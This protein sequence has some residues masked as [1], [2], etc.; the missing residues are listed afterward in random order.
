MILTNETR[1]PPAPPRTPAAG[2]R[3]AAVPPL[4]PGAL[5]G[6]GHAPALLRDPLGFLGSLSRYGDVVRIRLGPRTVCVV[7]D[8]GL[9]H[10]LLVAL[11]HD[12]PRGAV[13]D[14]LKTAFGDGLLMS[15]GRAHR[16]RRR[17][18][19]PAFGPDRMAD[20]LAVMHRVTEERADRWRPGQVLDVAKEMNHLA[21]EIVTRALFDA[22][23]SEDATLAFHRALPDLVK[24]QIVQS[25]YPHPTLAR[26]PLPVNRRFDAAVRVLNRVVDQ[27]VNG[28]VPGGRSGGSGEHGTGIGIGIGS[29]GGSGEHGTGASGSGCPM[30][31]GGGARRP[32]LPALL[33]AAVD[34]ATGRPLTEADVRSE[35]IT[36]FGAGTET[37]ST[38]LTWLIDELVRHPHIEARVLA[39]LDEH[40][41]AGTVPTPEALARLPYTRAVTQEVVRLHAPNAFLMRTARVPV[42]L[43]SYRI[44]AGTELLYSLTAV[45]RDPALHPDPLRFDPGRW[46]DADGAEGTG[47][48]GTAAARQTF[49]PFGAGKHK[50]IGEAFAWAELTVA[51]AA[52]LRRWHPTAVPDARAREVV[53]TTVQAQGLR[54]RLAPR[55]GNRAPHAPGARRTPPPGGRDD[56]PTRC[57]PI[58]GPR[59]STLL[60]A[61]STVLPGRS[62]PGRS[63]PAALH[64]SALRTAART[65]ART[66][67]RTASRATDSRTASRTTDSRATDSRSSDSRS[68]SRASEA[69]T[70]SRT[71]DRTGPRPRGGGSGS[72][73]SEALAPGTGVV[74]SLASPRHLV[75]LG[76]ATTAPRPAPSPRTAPPTRPAGRTDAAVPPLLRPGSEEARTP[77]ELGAATARHG[78]WAL[79]HGLLAPADLARYQSYA[80]PELIGHAYPRARGT[81]LDLLVDILGWFTILDDRFDGPPGRDPAEARAIVGPLLA[82]VAGRPAPVAGP[83]P[84]LLDA[85]RELWQRQTAPM[86]PEWRRRTADE[87]RSCLETFLA[88]TVHRAARTHPDLAETVRLRRHA[89]CLYPFMGILE[90]VHGGEAPAALHRDPALHRLRANT[91][92][93]ATLI[94]DLY[95]ADREERQQVAAFNTVLTLQRVRGCTRARAVRSVGTRIARLTTESESLRR[96]LLLRYPEGGWYLHGTRELVEGVHAWTSTSRRYTGEDAAP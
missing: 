14:T 31:G 60:P 43:G 75:L 23:L 19:Q 87:W 45:H 82:V 90:H 92:D 95:S 52:I 64:T 3:R 12:C 78:D 74:R 93:V 63:Y 37:V 48:G 15:E 1:R 80:L 17:S 62:A 94:N 22:R 10:T 79:A 6:L 38:T 11:A 32:A 5:P 67:S 33:R 44:P 26:L 58:A 54:V 61:R 39:E 27:A 40:L 8:A 16:D 2:T 86:S 55:G 46:Y 42:T 28:T 91:A 65:V 7:T 13:Q 77:A 24:G 66:A 41:P 76:P 72:G 73:G 84:H 71:A 89:S 96:R 83:L 88:E 69:R 81:E 50:C 35:A 34:P 9:V 47:T 29:A 56:T 21:L 49:L 4:A 53:W 20:Y 18:I 30:T 25:L 85:W 51:T 57:L 70:V 68:A 36:M 59:R